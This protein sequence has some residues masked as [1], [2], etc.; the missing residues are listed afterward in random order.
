MGMP[1]IIKLAYHQVVL[2]IYLLYGMAFLTSMPEDTP[3][4]LLHSMLILLITS[5]P[6]GLY[7]GLVKF[8]KI[9]VVRSD[10]TFV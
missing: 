2:A 1:W 6:M 10:G 4:R 3:S 7:L 9:R 5:I 8:G